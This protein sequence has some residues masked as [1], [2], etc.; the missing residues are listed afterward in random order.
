MC[1]LVKVIIEIN[2]NSKNRAELTLF[3]ELHTKRRSGKGEAAHSCV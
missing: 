1:I 2:L 3:D